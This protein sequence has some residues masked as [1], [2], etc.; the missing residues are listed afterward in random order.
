VKLLQRWGVDEALIGDLAEQR[1]AGRSR[2][3][4]WRQVIAAV[5]RRLVSDVIAHPFRTMFAVAIGLILRRLTLAAWGTNGPAID[6][7][8]GDLFLG[9]SPLSHS[10][11]ITAVA[12]ANAVVLLPIWI[13]IGWAT[14]RLSP[15]GALLF[16]VASLGLALPTVSHQI[17]AAIG[18]V[19][20]SVGGQI[21]RF[22]ISL[23]S[24]TAAVLAGAAYGGRVAGSQD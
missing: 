17:I 20:P 14:A 10:T 24:F 6:M 13:A 15:G 19:R 8:I 23:G 9:L 11:L 5:A 4:F 1:A 2:A 12:A 16:V 3:W 18:A 22:A 21:A 7:Q